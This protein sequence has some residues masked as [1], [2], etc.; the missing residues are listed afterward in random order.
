MSDLANRKIFISI[1][2]FNDPML[3][4]TLQSAYQNAA[5]PENLVF[6]VVDQVLAN[7]RQALQSLIPKAEFRYVQV[8]PVESQGVCWA[9]SLVQSF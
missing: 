3:A 6:A 2:A 8:N 7:Q 9:R 1:A 5:H 4:F